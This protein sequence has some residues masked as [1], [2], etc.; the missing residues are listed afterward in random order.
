MRVAVAAQHEGRDVLDRDAQLLGQEVA[1]ARASRA[2]PPC[3]PPAAGGRPETLLHRPDHGVERV[4]DDDDEGVGRVLLDVLADRLHDAG[5]DAD[6]VVAAHAGLARHAGG[7][8]HHVGA[9]DGRVVA[10]AGDRGV[11]ALDRRA[12][13][14]SSALPA[15]MPSTMSNRT[16]SPSS[17]SAGQQGERAAD[18]AGADRARSSCEPCAPSLRWGTMLPP[19]GAKRSAAYLD[20]PLRSDKPSPAR[21]PAAASCVQSA[22]ASRP[23]LTAYG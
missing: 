8:D 12:W 7:D 2:R 22:L 14:R 5:V 20:P 18:L 4:G 13:A 10:R 6:Q 19:D 21:H 23:P 11:E 15:G 16:T 1:E 9:R 17:F 3:R